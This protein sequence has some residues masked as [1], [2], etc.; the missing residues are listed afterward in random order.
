MKSKSMDLDREG[1]G[2]RSVC[3]FGRTA[4]RP[5]SDRLTPSRP[6]KSIH[7]M[8]IRTTRGFMVM[9]LLCACRN[10]VTHLNEAQIA[11]ESLHIT[12]D[13][14]ELFK[15]AEQKE[16]LILFPCYPCDA[17]NTRTEFNITE[18]AMDNH[19]AVLLMN[20]NQRLWLSDLEK[21]E[22]TDMLTLAVQEHELVAS[23][24]FIGG[25]SSGGNVSLLLSD[26][27]KES[28]SI[29]E[30]KGVFIA[31]SPVDLLALYENAQETVRKDFSDIAIQEAQWIIE[32]SHRDFGQGDTAITLYESK[33]PYVSKTDNTSNLSHL[34]DVD[35]RLYTEPD[36]TWWIENRQA[37]YQNMNACY[38]EQLAED[39]EQ[40][41]GKKQVHFI[42]TKNRGFRAN[43][44]RHPHSWA[45]IDE[46][47]LVEW[48]L[49]DE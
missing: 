3:I 12:T 11:P 10:T 38:I 27:L 19:I 22:L 41:Y 9:V 16:L 30:P 15:P 21:T 20:F 17:E 31:D 28:K 13:D 24:T 45:I 34:Q 47:E 6:M 23:N 49:K 2:Q 29:V 8:L 4:I 18:L 39:L 46:H 25:F 35:I 44:D 7:P 36:T 42:R 5:T 37:N 32:T 43:G 48:M 40:R 1:I 14:Y 33:S 26:H